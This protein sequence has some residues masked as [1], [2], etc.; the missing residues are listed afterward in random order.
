M[1]V[2]ER[3]RSVACRVDHAHVMYMRM[4]MCVCVTWR[5][6]PWRAGRWH[7]GG[8]PPVVYLS[9]L[10]VRWCVSQDWTCCMWCAAVYCMWY[11]RALPLE[12]VRGWGLVTGRGE[13]WAAV[14]AMRA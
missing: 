3:C 1:I 6:V 4:Y 10:C 11:V 14:S 8:Y 13:A 12:R 5:G 9:A 2:S 7:D